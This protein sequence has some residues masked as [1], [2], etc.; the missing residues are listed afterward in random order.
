M[1]RGVTEGRVRPV[2]DVLALTVHGPVGA[3]DLV[4]PA[5]AVVTDVARE[6]ADQAGLGAIP[7]LYSRTGDLLLASATLSEIG[8]GTG[9]ILVAATGVHRSSPASATR[10]ASHETLCD[11]H[12]V[13]VLWCATAAG[14]GV[15]AAWCAARSSGAGHDAAVGVLVVAAVLGLVPSRR[16]VIPRVLAAPC[17]LGAAG[18]AW[19]WDPAPERLPMVL[20]VTAGCLAVG[21][22]LVR[23]VAARAEAQL[24]VLVAAGSL[25]FTLT[26]AL[27][28]LGWSP[29][30][31]WAILLA[32]ALLA[33]RLVPGLAVDVPDQYLVDVERLA[34]TAWSARDPAPRRR[35]RSIVPMAAVSAVADRGARVLGV[36]AGVV[37]VVVL[38]TAPLLLWSASL[39]IDRVGA[40]IEVALVGLGLLLA[41][42]SY[43]HPEARALLRVAGLACGV[44]LAAY[45]APR[46]DRGEL[47]AVALG[48]IGLGLL[49]VVAAMATGRGWRSAWWSRRAEVAEALCGSSALAV[50]LVASGFFRHL[51]EL[52]S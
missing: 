15:L 22:A 47:L 49:L 17:F 34:V 38:V 46:L 44:A 16:S 24:G 51:W 36:A 52:A 25:V 10:R 39:P 14:V 26:G 43:R 7:L 28:L 19:A 41:A 1:T 23:A 33:A 9:S 35:V 48:A 27:T 20:G 37:L 42:R 2:A 40:R 18:F 31:A 12:R 32:S 21:A 6:Y 30:A 13:A 50:V 29:R 5:N 11:G 45:A 8:V 3:L 4:V